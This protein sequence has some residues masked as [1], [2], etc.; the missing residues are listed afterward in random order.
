MNQ[1]ILLLDNNNCINNISNIDNMN[2]VNN[3]DNINN[4]DR[5]INK[6]YVSP[7]INRMFFNIKNDS[8][9]IMIMWFLL[10]I[11]IVILLSLV[12][13]DIDDRLETQRVI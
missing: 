6:W 12:I 1:T 13:S 9:E 4:V 5:Q 8:F 10:I 3:V 7:T 2:N 11:T